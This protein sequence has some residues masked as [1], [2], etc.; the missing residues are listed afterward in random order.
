ML[1]PSLL[2]AQ[3][4]PACCRQTEQL[5]PCPLLTGLARA[6]SGAWQEKPLAAKHLPGAAWQERHETPARLAGT[7]A[8]S[9]QL[10]AGSQPALKLHSPAPYS[11][12]FLLLN[13]PSLFPAQTFLPTQAGGGGQ[14]HS[15]VLLV[16]PDKVTSTSPA[17]LHGGNK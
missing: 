9:A 6:A 14:S 4:T 3:V 15:L 11:A 17:L 16:S 8:P 5:G 2:R 7:S 12:L 1:E 13:S 10:G